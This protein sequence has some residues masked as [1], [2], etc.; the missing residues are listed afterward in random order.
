MQP[1]PGTQCVHHTFIGLMNGSSTFITL[2]HK[3]QVPQ[4][5]AITIASSLLASCRPRRQDIAEMLAARK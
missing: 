4:L 1:L 2:Q 5:R 3:V